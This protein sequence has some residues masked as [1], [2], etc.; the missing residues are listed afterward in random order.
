[1]NIYKAY[2]SGNIEELGSLDE[3]KLPSLLVESANSVG[4]NDFGIGV[5]R[6]K[7]DFVEIRP[8]GNEHYLVWS[9]R[10][11]KIGSFWDRLKQPQHIQKTVTGE[12]EALKAIRVY[13]TKS[14]EA[15]EKAYT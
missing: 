6:S 7:K 5:N 3:T 9:D 14:R 10:L 13:T 15:F 11:C 2:E 8:V 4:K 1:M 12:T